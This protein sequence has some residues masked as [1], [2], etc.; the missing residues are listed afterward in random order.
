MQPTSDSGPPD[1]RERILAAALRLLD[2]A[3][4]EAL[5]ARRVAA[6]VGSSTMVVYTHFGGMQQLIDA[7][8]LEGFRRFGAAL[9]STASSSDPMADLFEQ[10]L[11][12]RE[13][14]LANPHLYRLMFGVSETRRHSVAGMQPDAP[15]EQIAPVLE[16]AV[17]TELGQV[18]Y[19][20]FQALLVA[21]DRVGNSHR[22]VM[23]DPQPEPYAVSLQLWSAL[24]GYVMLETAGYFGPGGHG[25]DLVLSALI[26][27]LAVGMGDEPAAAAASWATALERRPVS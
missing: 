4:P 9:K 25:I 14:A 16:G 26:R 24:H 15:V 10:A 18:A 19:A 8:A 5:Q 22:I 2:E 3:G 17:P 20:A 27:T 11:A 23:S 6:A 7:V 21:V 12:Y 1:P 13:F